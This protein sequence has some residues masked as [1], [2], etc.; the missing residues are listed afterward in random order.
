[1]SESQPKTVEQMVAEARER[2]HS[3]SVEEVASEIEAGDVLLVD[4]REDDERL[5]E[6]TI[7]GSLHVPRGLIELS[8]DPTSPLYR[9]EFD[10]KR[11]VIVYC[12]SGIRSALAADTLRG[13]GYEEVAQLDG[14]MMAWKQDRRPVQGVSFG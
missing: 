5:L 12:S 4:L 6:G 13:M 14:G 2:I 7:P 10:P 3:L 9:R 11:R 8:A 1:M